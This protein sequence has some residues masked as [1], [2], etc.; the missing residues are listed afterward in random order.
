MKY[1]GATDY[2]IRAP[3]VIEGMII[4]FAGSLIP[5]VL[6]YFFYGKA[7]NY[8]TSRFQM[9]TNLMNFLPVGD[10]MKSLIPVS[11]LIG[12]GIGFFGSMFTV[13]RH[14]RDEE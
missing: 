10:I 3:F 4:G 5:L 6:I 11:I 12:V 9:L 1:V 8:I 2:F 7:V 13:H 14:L